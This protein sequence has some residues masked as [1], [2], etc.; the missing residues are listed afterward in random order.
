MDV[1]IYANGLVVCSVCVPKG[2][3]RSVIEKQVN[4]IN[5]TG[6]KYKW[7]IAKDSHFKTGQSMPCQCEQDPDRL[8]YLLEC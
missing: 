7:K 3:E 8:H 2:M 5:P 4:A 6:I 1:Y